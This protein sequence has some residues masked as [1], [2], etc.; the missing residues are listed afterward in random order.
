MASGTGRKAG[1]AAGG[2]EAPISESPLSS[3]NFGTRAL[4]HVL[5]SEISDAPW[6]L[7]PARSLTGVPEDVT[8]K[9]ARDALAATGVCC[10]PQLL[11]PDL[12]DQLRAEILATLDATFAQPL[13]R[14]VQH[15]S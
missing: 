5:L 9:R 15:Y 4:P 8:L 10:A 7:P 3:A 13:H 12:V 6:L 11:E 1:V 14:N 2:D